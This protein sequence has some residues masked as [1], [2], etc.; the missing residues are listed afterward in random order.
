MGTQREKS[1]L[2]FRGLPVK[3]DV[4]HTFER[5][6]AGRSLENQLQIRLLVLEVVPQSFWFIGFAS[7]NRRV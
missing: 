5:N 2:Q 4:V 1:H 6:P 3:G 7:S